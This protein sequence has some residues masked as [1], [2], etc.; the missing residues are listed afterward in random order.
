MAL[1][2]ILLLAAIFCLYQVIRG[3]VKRAANGLAILT[4]LPIHAFMVANNTFIEP[5]SVGIQLFA[6]DM[7]FLLLAMLFATLPVT[8]GV[9]AVIFSGHI[10]LHLTVLTGSNLP[11]SLEFTARTLR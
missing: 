7:V 1:N 3:N 8:L 6:F 10:Y 2:L 9:L 5:V 4:V 11:G